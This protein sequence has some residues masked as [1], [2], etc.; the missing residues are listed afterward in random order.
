MMAARKFDDVSPALLESTLNV[1]RGLGFKSMTPVQSATLPLFLGN[2]D[3]CVEA[4]TGSG[5]TVAYVI[6]VVEKLQRI[7]KTWQLHEV[8]ALILSPTRFVI[9]LNWRTRRRADS[10]ISSV[11]QFVRWSSCVDACRELAKQIF[12]VVSIFAAETVL[13]PVLL[14]G[15]TEVQADI[16]R[17][18]NKGCNVVVATPGRLLDL[19]RR[20]AAT[21]ISFKSLEVLVLDEAD[22]LLD[23][24]FTDAL[25]EILGHLPKQ[26]RTG[27]F[28]A[29]QTQEVKAL[30]RA[31]LR[32][33]A[34][35]T[36]QVK[37]GSTAAAAAS[38]DGAATASSSSSV[39]STPL[40]LSNWYTMCQSPAD[41]LSQLCAFLKEREAQKHKCIVFALTCASVD[42]YAK[43]FSSQAVRTAAGLPS[44]ADFPILPLHGQ[45]DPKKR[46]GNYQKF[47]QSKSGV[48]LCT[49]VAARGIDVPDV[50]WIVQFDPPQDPSFYIHRVGRTAR[51]GR[52]GA[53]LLLLLPKENS[54]IHL[55]G[56]RNVPISERKRV[57]A[58][59]EAEV[60]AADGGDSDGDAAGESSDKHD[61]GGGRR[62]AASSA[63]AGAL[64][65][66]ASCAMPVD[67]AA[68]T[69][70]SPTVLCSA[71]QQ[72]SLLDRDVL[73]KG[74][75]AFI[76][77]LRGYKEH[78]CRAIF[79]MEALDISSLASSFGLVKLPKVDELRGRKDINFAGV[80]GVDTGSIAYKDPV[81]ETQRQARLEAENEKKSAEI[82]ARDARRDKAYKQQAKVDA[83]TATA[84]ASGAAGKIKVPG[85]KR[86]RSHKGTQAKIFED[87]DMLGRE[88][89][90]EK[91]LKS[92]KISKAEY[93]RELGLLHREQGIDESDDDLV[94]LTGKDSDSDGDDGLD[95]DDGNGKQKKS[96]AKGSTQGKGK[97][98][99]KQRAGSDSDDE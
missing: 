58:T 31:G 16:D 53:A 36:V 83:A 20:G 71:L 63:G 39:Q 78:H 2:K 26:R 41:K 61:G 47:V 40:S 82:A 4:C 66:S 33:P 29:T 43:L 38:S 8:G 9:F 45:M 21:G 75:K 68:A 95:S 19:M 28:S 35:V 44:P 52:K 88:E 62:P 24:G 65:S 92:G 97:K 94:G 48:L 6:P 89:R 5:K 98:V 30:A 46:T 22:T 74:T 50:D 90:L 23:M 11:S 27:L 70:P 91:R 73:E 72:E 77:F 96:Q 85:D 56:V 55:L 7:E 80:P 15:G 49:D 54:Y 25:T 12:N 87:W 79:R 37:H 67:A 51:A 69:S 99:K 32:N 60:V 34:I 84:E 13:K 93:K 14:T 59:D 64:S 76:S 3:V 42:I 18:V 1:I 57:R 17:C 86:K 81:R 10:V